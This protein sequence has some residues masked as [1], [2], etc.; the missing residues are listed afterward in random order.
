[1][2]QKNKKEVLLMVLGTSAASILEIMKLKVK[3]M[4]LKDRKL[5][6]KN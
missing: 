3:Q 1:M 4:L 2:K 6:E 5:N